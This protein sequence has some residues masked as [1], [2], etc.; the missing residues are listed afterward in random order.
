MSVASG[1][2]SEM[3]AHRLA[4]RVLGACGF[5]TNRRERNT[6]FW[7]IRHT[8][9]GT[10]TVGIPACERVNTAQRPPATSGSLCGL[11]KQLNPHG[12]PRVRRQRGL[13][14]SE[15]RVRYGTRDAGAASKVVDRDVLPRLV[16]E[17]REPRR[18][19]RPAGGLHQRPCATT[20]QRRAGSIRL[21]RR[22]H[23]WH[24]CP[25]Y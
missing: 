13:L 25:G 10:Q 2:R 3:K 19:G 22:R 21:R 20:P 18:T 7:S 12:R 1:G 14:G 4:T 17:E 9:T 11:Q 8:D 15:I 24:V 5:R 23:S 6:H 16:L